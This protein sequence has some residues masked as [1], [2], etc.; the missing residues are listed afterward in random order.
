[1]SF[2]QCAE[3]IHWLAGRAPGFLNLLQQF[4]EVYCF[5]NCDWPNLG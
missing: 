2:G 3:D 4:S 5:G 1:M